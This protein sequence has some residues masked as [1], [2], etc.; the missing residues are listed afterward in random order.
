MSYF[1]TVSSLLQSVDSHG[2]WGG[3]TVGLPSALGSGARRRAQGRGLS[4]IEPRLR[5]PPFAAL[6]SVNVLEMTRRR[7]YLSS[8]P[9]RFLT[10]VVSLEGDQA[11]FG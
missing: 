11:R 3:L 6:T 1:G 4:E 5:C 2:L 10:A 9:S 8:T 7:D